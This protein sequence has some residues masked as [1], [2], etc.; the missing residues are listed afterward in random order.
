V[1]VAVKVEVV[2]KKRVEAEK[3]MF[4]V[5]VKLLSEVRIYVVPL[6]VQTAPETDAVQVVARVN[7]LGTVRVSCR[8]EG[9][10]GLTVNGEVM[11]MV[12][13]EVESRTSVFVGM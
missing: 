1:R 13:V 11:V 4:M 3:I 9:V 12:R 8:R 7:W 6:R 10:E 2:V 5:L